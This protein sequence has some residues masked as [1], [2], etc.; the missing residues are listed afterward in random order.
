MIRKDTG[1]PNEGATCAWMAADEAVGCTPAFLTMWRSSHRLV[2]RERPE[3][4]LRVKDIS[5]IHWSQ[6]LLTTQSERPNGRATRLA[7]H[8]ASIMPM[9]LPLSNCNSC[10]YCHR[11]R[12]NGMPTSAFPL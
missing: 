10:S 1:A 8:P 12:R 4:G 11:K 2:R 5:R 6:H 7:D 3:P 9:I